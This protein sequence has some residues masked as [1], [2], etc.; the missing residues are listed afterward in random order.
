MALAPKVEEGRLYNNIVQLTATDPDCGKFGE[1][2]RYEITNNASPFQ[3]NEQ[4]WPHLHI[5]A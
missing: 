4:G 2:C 3:I 5:M 1:I